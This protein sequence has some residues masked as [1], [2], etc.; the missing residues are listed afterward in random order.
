MDNSLYLDSDA[1][2]DNIWSLIQ[3]FEAKYPKVRIEWLSIE[4][5]PK[6]TSFDVMEKEVGINFS[7]K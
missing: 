7:V 5:S 3:S 4:R 1:L 2:S 6:K